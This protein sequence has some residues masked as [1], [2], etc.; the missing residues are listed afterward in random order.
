MI[1][2]YGMAWD[3]SGFWLWTINNPHLQYFVPDVNYPEP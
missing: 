2:G 1:G 3:G